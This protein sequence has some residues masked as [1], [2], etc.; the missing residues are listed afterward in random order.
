MKRIYY[1]QWLHHR[2]HSWL[3]YPLYSRLYQ[4]R[5]QDISKCLIIA[6]TA[7]SG[8][9]WAANVIS[10]Q[11]P[12][13]VMFEPFHAR[14]IPELS[15]FNYFQYQRPDSHNDDLY[16]F[17]LRVFSGRIRHQWIDRQVLSLFP[18][19]RIIKEI[20]INLFLKWISNNFPVIPILF[21]IRHPCAVVHSR[22]QLN[23]ATDDDIDSFLSQERLIEDFLSDK[24]DLIRRVKTPEE[25]HAIIWCISNLIPIKQFNSSGLNIIFYENLCIQ[26][27][28]EIP[29][30]FRIIGLDYNRKIFSILDNPS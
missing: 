21:V 19:Y 26:P 17:C 28:V 1:K 24:I 22:M 7:R 5:N 18:K 13:R 10:S 9:T 8:T 23:W 4:D 6:G 30:I 12:A 14:M 15:Q 16:T 20:R 25:K 3:L 11:I 29:R 2:I 27:E